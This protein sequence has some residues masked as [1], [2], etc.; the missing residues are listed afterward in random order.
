ML[1]VLVSPHSLPRVRCSWYRID[2]VF[3]GRKVHFALGCCLK[4]G[5]RAIFA[6][7][8][9]Y[10][11]DENRSRYW[12]AIH[13]WNRRETPVT[14]DASVRGRLSE[15]CPKNPI[16]L[17]HH[18]SW[19]RTSIGFS[20]GPT[21]YLHPTKNGP[22]KSWDILARGLCIGYKLVLNVLVFTNSTCSA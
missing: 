7:A 3:Q 5:G 4:W 6:H 19:F 15:M 16:L 21:G 12:V 8:F 1:T 22:C 11:D 14:T 2:C 9:R 13:R 20:A 17:L 10:V 18:V